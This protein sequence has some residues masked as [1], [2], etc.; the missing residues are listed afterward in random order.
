M[1]TTVYTSDRLW[2]MHRLYPLILLLTRKP[3]NGSYAVR[4]KL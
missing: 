2:F 3:P 4:T 1:L